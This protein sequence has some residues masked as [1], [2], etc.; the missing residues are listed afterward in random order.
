M[1]IRGK[2]LL[3][4][5]ALFGGFLIAF[6][7]IAFRYF[8]AYE[9][10]H[11]ELLGTQVLNEAKMM[12]NKAEMIPVQEARVDVI[13]A[14]WSREIENF[15][16]S[17]NAFMKYPARKLLSEDIK[18]RITSVEST[19]KTLQTTVLVP[20]DKKMQEFTRTTKEDRLKSRGF[21][22][23]MML[24][25][26][27][28]NTADPV[29]FNI[30]TLNSFSSSVTQSIQGELVEPLS[31]IQS[32]LI[33][34]INIYINQVFGTTIFMSLALLA[35]AAA[36]GFI[37]SRA[38]TRH[39]QV[40]EKTISEITRGNFDIHLEIKTDD[41][42]GLLSK[43]FNTLSTE[44][45]S[46]LDALKDIMQ[47]IA[48]S[49]EAEKAVDIEQ[50]Y[51]LILELAIDS[52]KADAGLIMTPD[53]EDPQYLVMRKTAGFFPM[54]ITLP[55]R[56]QADEETILQYYK[57]HPLKFGDTPYGKA[58]ET[59]KPVF[60][61][62]NGKSRD[63]E[64]NANPENNFYIKSVMIIPLVVSRRL[65]GVLALCKKQ[66]DG[67]FSDLD[68]AYMRSFGD[69]VALTNDTL[70][71]YLE[72]LKKHELTR[73]IEVAADIQ[74]SL[75]PQKMP[76]IKHA[77]IHGFSF[78]AKGVSGDYFDVFLINPDQ[79]AVIICDV[80]GKGVPASLL[81]IMIRTVLRTISA[82]GKNACRILT[83]L[84]R[85]ITGRLGADRFATIGF[86]IFDQKTME[87]SYSNGAHHP[88]YIYRAS[89]SKF[90]MFDTDGLPLGIDINAAYG[91]KK[92]RVEKGDYL[93]LYTDG[94]SEAR[95]A[96]GDEL[97]N[98]RLLRFVA[99]N[100]DVEPKKMSEKVKK[101]LDQFVGTAKQH[102]DET[103]LSLRIR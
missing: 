22:Y 62:D 36:A 98:G 16:A 44:L 11:L 88:L 100:C 14:D 43:H 94:I 7:L 39:L 86:F 79:M 17:I 89:E 85:A 32:D 72:L 57:N 21:R 71:K 80:S 28:G 76:D 68:F 34:D 87:I 58:A 37:F 81:M 47:D 9:L 61:K 64:L 96:E 102:D 52:T 65:F 91:H 5:L 59:Q 19:W 101:F 2:L 69:F 67:G 1:K 60:I 73:E 12:R 75:L 53:P 10:Y 27:E 103:F 90:K 24:L 26:S 95:N 56:V 92:I 54:P 18:D 30:T 49:V 25:E 77:Q 31:V 93:V 33:A 23:S 51:D 8:R 4:Q 13:Q 66:P 46:R 63:M 15:D 99:K 6:G 38:V 74:K 78:A 82:P 42:F 55:T 83:E 48:N 41:E 29:Y 84:N 35:G 70:L 97:G 45:W 20:Y 50:F 40:I 3:I